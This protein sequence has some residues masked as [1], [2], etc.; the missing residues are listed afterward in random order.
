MLRQMRSTA[1]L[2]AIVLGIAMHA[3]GQVSS[4]AILGSVTD[5]S[6][7]LIPGVSITLTNQGTN[8]TREAITNES[9][10]YRVEPLQSGL[11]NI[12]AE[13]SGFKK[14]VRSGVRVEVDARV[15]MDF[16]LQV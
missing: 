8:Q 13:L 10:T 1:I 5:A 12:S 2:I 3:H 11:Y 16:A 4:G 7:A 6:G 14:E 15:R 9:G